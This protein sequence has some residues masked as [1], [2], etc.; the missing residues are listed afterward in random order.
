MPQNKRLLWKPEYS[1]GIPELDMQHKKLFEIISRLI[2]QY[3][4]KEPDLLATLTGLSEYLSFHFSNE[5]DVMALMR[6]PKLAEHTNS[7]TAFI[8]IFQGFVDRYEKNDPQL[9]KDMVLYLVNWLKTHVV[10]GSDQ[11]YAR[12]YADL[13][14]KKQLKARAKEK[15]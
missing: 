5:Q 6:Y 4:N 1:V 3:E 8:R 14:K 9:A 15:R 10:Q 7:H 2:T 12:F 11:D 13:L